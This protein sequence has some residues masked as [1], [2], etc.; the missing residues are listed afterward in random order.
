MIRRVSA[1]VMPVL[2]MPVLV[3][4]VLVNAGCGSGGSSSA[5]PRTAPRTLPRA[6]TLATMRLTSAAFADR[7]TIPARHTCDGE[8][9]SPPLAWSAPPRGT[10][11]QALLVLDPDAPGMN[12]RGNE[13]WVPP[14][15]PRGD[16]PHRYEFTIFALGRRSG[17]VPTANVRDFLDAIRGKVLATGKLTGRYGRESAPR[18]GRSGASSRASRASLPTGR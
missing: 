4:P 8:G 7:G 3:M 11:E 6:S 15:P 2:V 18:M 1:L 9:T 16:G 12:G 5:A 10:I 14:C 13:G 17:L